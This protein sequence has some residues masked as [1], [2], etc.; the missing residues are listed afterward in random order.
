MNFHGSLADSE[1]I[2]DLFVW[3][4]IYGQMHDLALANGQTLIQFPIMMKDRAAWSVL[5]QAVHS[6]PVDRVQQGRPA[7]RPIYVV[8][9]TQFHRLA[10]K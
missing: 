4:T 10:S 7:E 8:D 9:R 1:P 2:S 3:V 5:R 6:Y